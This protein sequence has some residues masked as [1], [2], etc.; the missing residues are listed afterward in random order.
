MLM[1]GIAL[2]LTATAASADSSSL[3]GPGDCARPFRDLD[4]G[5]VSAQPTAPANDTGS[6]SGSPIDLFAPVSGVTGVVSRPTN[7]ID[8]IVALI[9]PSSTAAGADAQPASLS[10]DAGTLQVDTGALPVVTGSASLAVNA[11]TPSVQISATPPTVA[12]A[13]PVLSPS[14]PLV[15]TVTTNPLLA[16]V[17]TTIAPALGGTK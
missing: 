9:A 2:L 5:P 8:A 17:T 7:V 10:L 16:P 6:V 3:A 14:M 1:A 11:Q 15:N 12:P 13:I 4:T